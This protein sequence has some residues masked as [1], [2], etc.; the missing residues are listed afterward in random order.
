M[1][2]VQFANVSNPTAFGVEWSAGENGSQY[3]L[4]NPRG[5]EGL[6]FGMKVEGARQWS[7][8]PVVDPTRF[9]DTIPRTFNDFLKVAKA[10]VE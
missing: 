10:Y 2:E 3:Q 8:V 5:T 9:M 7:V 1:S 6:V 4:V